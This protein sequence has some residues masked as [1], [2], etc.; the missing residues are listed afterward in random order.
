M[1]NNRCTA[2]IKEG[3]CI[4]IA[5]IFASLHNC[6]LRHRDA[7]AQNLL[8]TPAHGGDSCK[9]SLLDLDGVKSYVVKTSSVRFRPLSK[10]AATLLSFGDVNMT[11]YL[12]TFTIYCNLTGIDVCRRK[13]IFREISRR[14]VAI[15]LLTMAKT[16]AGSTEKSQL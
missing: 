1:R 7:K 16:A 11:D 8:V 13:E 12:R 14:A 10:L 15:R 5:T 4:Q 2:A 3:M 9:V 6:G